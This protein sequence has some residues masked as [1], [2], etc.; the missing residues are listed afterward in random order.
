MCIMAV[1]IT[2]PIIDYCLVRHYDVVVVPIRF[3]I[4]SQ[5]ISATIYNYLN[6]L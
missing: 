2:I 4:V 1:I 3:R 6:I 5:G